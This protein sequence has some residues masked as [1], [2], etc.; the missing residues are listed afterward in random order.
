[1][2][3]CG[4]YLPIYLEMYNIR[5]EDV[6]ITAKLVEDHTSAEICVVTKLSSP[7]PSSMNFQVEIAD[8]EGQV[9]AKHQ[10]G[11]THSSTL[12]HK[13]TIQ[14]PNLWWP[15]GLGSQNLYTAKATL[16]S[17]TNT[18]TVDD[19]STKFG[20]RTITLIQRPLRFSPGTT[21][22]FSIN[23]QHTF[24]QG[25]NWVP[26]D[27]LLPHLTRSRYFS[28]L[29]MA[30]RAN[31]NMIRVWGGGIYESEDFFD[32]CDELGLLVWHDYAF[33]CGD[34]PV[35]EEFLESVAK[36]VRAQT[37]RLRNRASLAL[38]CGGNEDFMLADEEGEPLPGLWMK[39][40]VLTARRDMEV[41]MFDRKH[42]DHT[43]TIGPF[44]DSEFP[45]RKLYLDIIPKI[46]KELCPGIQYWPNSPWGGKEK[47]ND[48]TVG[49]IHQ[50]DGKDTLFPL[51]RLHR[52]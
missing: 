3:A 28:I 25:A 37:I 45:Q 24:I 20:I 2:V 31:F 27:N 15:N 52:P 17:S 14:D 30:K 10:L 48:P 51:I 9:V 40:L 12:D 22:M 44:D 35:H 50:W 8:A 21:F 26:A 36:E 4:P 7:L 46:V 6:S 29:N 11:N 33:A 47:A 49:D 42:Y 1:M 39:T 18:E 5:I 13:I 16:L 23:N 34:F 41:L 43:D 19:K 32:A 38:I